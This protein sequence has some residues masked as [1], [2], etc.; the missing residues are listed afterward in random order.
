M[1]FPN[2]ICESEVIPV[3][4]R[5]G[6]IKVLASPGTLGTTRLI[7]GTAVLSPGEEISEHIHDYGEEIVY[8]TN[9]TG[10]IFI[11]DEKNVF[12]KGSALII[13]HGQRHRI[14]NEGTDDITMVFSSAPLAPYKNSGHRDIA[15]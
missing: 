11:E 1:V 13:R 5:G 4:K 2:L 8:V 7:L 12:E 14:V 10:T 3:T 15:K 6:R 9:G